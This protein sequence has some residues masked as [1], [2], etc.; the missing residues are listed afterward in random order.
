MTLRLTLV[1]HAPTE[2]T[3]R[4]RFPLDEPADDPPAIPVDARAQALTSVALRA[5]QTADA[6]GVSASV[7]HRL[8]DW[9]LGTWAGRTLDDVP[10]EALQ[11][12]LGDP[13]AAPHG[14][15]SLAGLL[16]RVGGLLTEL[17][18]RDATV[19]AFTH[20]A[21][22]RAATVHVLDA[23]LAA[24]WRVDVEPLARLSLTAAAG[25]WNLRLR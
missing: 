14:G 23:P 18:A 12:W 7:D 5:R 8:D 2:A 19:V 9:N 15:E 11:A 10:P 4:H 13:D 25:R 6:A 16:I 17:S 3:R 24:F 22:L 20:P 1:A 21:V